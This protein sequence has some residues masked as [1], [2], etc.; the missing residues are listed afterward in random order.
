MRTFTPDASCTRRRT[1]LRWLCS[2]HPSPGRSQSVNGSRGAVALLAA[3]AVALLSLAAAS[4]ATKRPAIQNGGTL[5]VGLTT[6]TPTTLDP[7]RGPGLASREVLRTICET[8]YDNNASGHVVPLLASG[9]ATVSKDKLTVTIPLRKGILFNDGTPFNS[10][11]VAATFQRDITLPGSGRATVLG[12]GT[13]VSTDGPYDVVLH[14]ATPNVALSF[15]LVNERVMSPV[16]LA[17]LGSSFGNDPVCVGPFRFQSDVP[18]QSVTVVRSPYYYDKKDVHLDEIVFAAET[19]DLAA[20]SALEAGDVQAL[21]QVPQDVLKS[22]EQNGFRVLGHLSIGFNYIQV[23]V[24]NS[25]GINS[26]YSSPGTPIASSPLLREAFEMA[27][28]RK[29]LNRVVFGGLNVPGCTLIS[30][31]APDWYDPAVRCTPYDPVQA[32]KLVQQSGYSNP[33]VQLS[34]GSGVLNQVLAQFVQSEEQAVGITVTLDPTDPTTL[35]ARENSGAYQT[36]LGAFTPVKS[37]PDWLY[38]NFLGPNGLPFNQF[39][40]SNPRVTLDLANSRKAVNAQDRKTVVDDA[41]K[42]L[43]ADRPW[44]VLDHILN[45]A[46]FSNKLTGVQVYSDQYLRVAFAGWTAPPAT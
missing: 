41:Q 6:G 28:D 22:V 12:Q 8:L 14:L 45:R 30:P 38:V 35:G 4:G 1:M 25:N 39:G 13:T 19:S 32:R 44:I 42:Q 40:Y 23:N 46:A 36:A 24:G 29:T 9:P 31:A 43:L 10:A 16:Q 20:A 7:D 27:I 26:P 15:G 11:A 3:A 18:G 34:Y 37:D 17:S 33:T 5:T 21:D 2:A